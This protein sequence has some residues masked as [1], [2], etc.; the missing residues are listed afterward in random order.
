MPQ[1]L[2]ICLNLRPTS[3][4]LYISEYTVHVVAES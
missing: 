4:S 2:I 3:G 1:G